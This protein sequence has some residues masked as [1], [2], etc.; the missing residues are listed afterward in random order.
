MIKKCYTHAY[1]DSIMK[2][3]KHFDKGE[4]REGMRK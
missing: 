2:F 3:P 4:R 1:E